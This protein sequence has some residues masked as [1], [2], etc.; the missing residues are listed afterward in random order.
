MEKKKI[1]FIDILIVLVVIVAGVVGM[2]MLKGTAGA[3]TKLVTYTVLVADQKPD[4]AGNMKPA[5]NVL[6]DTQSNI[7]GDITDVE[8]RPARAPYFNNKTGAYVM[9]EI[10]ERKDVYVTVSVEATDNEWGYDIG[11]THIRV[12]TSQVISGHGFAVS[13]YIIDVQED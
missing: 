1:T 5:K 7:Y 13:G 6:L 2:K 9:E 4:V 8:I 10:N 3:N 12:G 11:E